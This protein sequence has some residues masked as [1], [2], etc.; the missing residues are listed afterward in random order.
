MHKLR[1]RAALCYESE[2]ASERASAAGSLNLICPSCVPFGSASSKSTDEMPEFDFE[3]ARSIFDPQTGD[4]ER[5]SRPGG[6][7]NGS[8]RSSR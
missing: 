7:S 5:Q 1:H 6:L 3:G 4:F 2:R 8:L